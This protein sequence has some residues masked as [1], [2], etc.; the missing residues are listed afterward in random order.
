MNPNHFEAAALELAELGYRTVPLGGTRKPIQPGW[1]DS[2]SDPD[3]TRDRFRA[4]RASGLAV[5]TGDLVVIDRDRNHADGV[6]GVEAFDDLVRANG[7]QLPLGP[8]VST[9]NHGEHSWMLRPP[10][11]LVRSSASRIAPGVDIKG[12]RSCAVCPPTPGYEWIVHPRDVAPPM[13]PPWLLGLVASK[14]PPPRPMHPPRD[15]DGAFSRYGA[16]ALARE[17]VALYRC[18][19]GKRA[20]ALFAA[21]ARLGALAAGGVLPEQKVREALEDA[22]RACGLVADDGERAAFTHIERG[23]AAG[24]LHPRAPRD[25]RWQR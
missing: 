5:V 8:R 21:S 2:T 17:L 15:Y 19:Q 6:D 20:C 4:V 24:R 10:E 18:R 14:P 9:R 22:A 16:A 1:P 11:V 3:A 12:F 25:H 7:G 23:L 13:P